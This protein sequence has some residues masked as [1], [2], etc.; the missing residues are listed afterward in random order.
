MTIALS[1]VCVV[2]FAA[3]IALGTSRANR[4]FRWLCGDSPNDYGHLVFATIG[5]T[6]GAFVPIGP[7]VAGVNMI[8]IALG[9]V[10]GVY[11]LAGAIS[12]AMK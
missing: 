6:V 4:V 5:A 12:M 10:A 3:L 11:V 9:A 7:P 1:G 8:A 2:G